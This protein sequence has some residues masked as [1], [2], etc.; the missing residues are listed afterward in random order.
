MRFLRRHLALSVLIFLTLSWVLIIQWALLASGRTALSPA[1]SAAFAAGVAAASF[2]LVVWPRRGR[3]RRGRSRWMSQALMLT[4]LGALFSGPP[5]IIAFA[6]IGLPLFARGSPTTEPA[7]IA[8][9]AVAVSI[10]FGSIL[11]GFLVGQ[12]RLSVERVDLPVAGL[13][14]ALAGVRVAQITDLH[15]GPQLRAKRL[16][17]F[18]ERVNELEADLI[19]ITGDIFDFDPTFIDEGCAE[20][21]KLEAT[22]GVFAVLGNHD[23]YTGAD[24][25]ASGLA[26]HTRIRLLRDE[27]LRLEIRGRSLFLLGIDDPGRAFAS[28]TLESPA[29]EQL[30]RDVPADEARLLLMHRPSYFPQVVRLGLPAALAG[31]THGGQVS[32]PRPAH[33]HNVSRLIS[34]WTVGLFREGR[35]AMYVSRGL[36]VAGPPVRLNCPRE[37]SLLRLVPATTDG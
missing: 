29:L 26:R 30:A 18:V 32:L 37:I 3:R 1:G 25:V 33:H 31:H 4:N 7:L 36:G 35:S 22:H 11:W 27:S 16:A 17:G 19:A 34:E 28:R 20:L 21:A 8:A 24:A 15:I 10:G 14:P 2:G 9:G 6:A 12:R 13:D 23:V 5:L